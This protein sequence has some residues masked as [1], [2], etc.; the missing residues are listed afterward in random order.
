MQTLSRMHCFR[1]RD[2]AP[3]VDTSRAFDEM[4]DDA[5]ARLRYRFTVDE[6]RQL[7]SKLQLPV[8]GV[9]TTEGDNVPPVEALAMVC[10]R[11]SEA[12]KLFTVASEF[13]RSTASYSRVFAATVQIMYDNHRVILYFH[14]ALI[15]ERIDEYCDTTHAAG[16]PLRTCSGFIDGTKQYISRPSARE[17]PTIAN[18]HLQRSVYNGHPRRHWFNW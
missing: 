1:L 16:A 3:S 11:L 10:R 5:V 17:E 18:E 2:A 15:K 4:L 14:D 8:D 9:N 6:L 13:G 7:A 12:L